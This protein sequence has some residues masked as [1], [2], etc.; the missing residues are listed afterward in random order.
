MSSA[1]SDRW[2]RVSFAVLAVPILWGFSLVAAEFRDDRPIQKTWAAS[3]WLQ[4]REVAPGDAVAL[5]VASHD[6]YR[7][8][9]TSIDARIGSTT[10]HIVGHKPDWGLQIQRGS[11][12]DDLA[13]TVTIPSGTSPGN[14]RIYL[15]IAMT[16]AEAGADRSQL[17]SFEN[18][19]RTEHLSVPLEVRDPGSRT[20]HRVADAALAVGGWLAAFGLAFLAARVIAGRRRLFAAAT[21]GDELVR[22]IVVGFSAIAIGCGVVVAGES[23]FV[24]PILGT[25]A[26]HWRLLPGGLHALWSCALAV[27]AWS[28]WRTSRHRA[29]R[30][31]L[32]NTQIP[33]ADARVT[34]G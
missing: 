5:R 23:V 14:E 20:L 27:G 25:T 21:A 8:A 19:D 9:I 16:T 28:G 2:T 4:T 26:W 12:G 22:L 10:S 11:N 7:S 30:A 1:H 18:T 3:V 17:F 15:D 6:G 33:L 32:Q 29:A 34:R 24:R 31:E 13:F